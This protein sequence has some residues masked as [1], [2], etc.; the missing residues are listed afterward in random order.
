MNEY[1]SRVAPNILPLSR[2]KTLPAAFREWHVTGELIDH[3]AAEEQCGL[4]EQ[5]GLRYHF[6]I[7]NDLTDGHLWVGSR[8]ILQFEIPMYDAGRLLGPKEVK[9]ELAQLVKRKRFEWCLKALRSVAATEQNDILR[10]ALDYF[11][12][13]SNLS[14]KLAWVVFW[15]LR[16]HGIGHDP[17]WFKV[18]LRRM[19]HRDDLRA[20]PADRVHELWPALSASQRR[21]AQELGHSPPHEMIGEGKKFTY[22]QWRAAGWTDEQLRAKKLMR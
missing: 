5:E 21:L 13:H 1:T 8:C 22:A 10:G 11:E 2:A 20:M 14:P 17:R 18:A 16:Q 9:R 6:G 12:Q 4:C 15:K 19:K 3:E 7:R